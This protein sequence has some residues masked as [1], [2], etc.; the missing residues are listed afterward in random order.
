[1]E[2]LLKSVSLLESEA[3]MR[4]V[5]PSKN[6]LVYAFLDSPLGCCLFP[7]LQITVHCHL[8]FL[9]GRFPASPGRVVGGIYPQICHFES[10][11]IL[12][13]IFVGLYIFFLL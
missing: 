12:N 8:E 7:V 2:F 10:G 3:S 5:S 9:M 13:V 11:K 4:C 6:V 1:M